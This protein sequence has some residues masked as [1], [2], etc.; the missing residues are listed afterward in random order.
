[1]NASSYGNSARTAHHG[2]MWK[3]ILG[4]SAV[5]A[6][7]MA[8]CATNPPAPLAFESSPDLYTLMF[9]ND[10]MRILAA[11][12]G[13]GDRSEMLW[14]PPG[15]LV[16]ATSGSQWQTTYSD[17]S[18]GEPSPEMP[19]TAVCFSGRAGSHHN[20]SDVPATLFIIHF[21][22]EAAN[23]SFCPPPPD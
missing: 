20:M 9:E 10:A 21:K 1:M 7:L 13:P 11:E 3:R 4:L 16:F 19:V 15:V 5:G 6:L 18:K 14:H 22:D 23:Q 12:Y 17:G 2:G 8:A